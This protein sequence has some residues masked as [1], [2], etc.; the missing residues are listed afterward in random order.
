MKESVKIG[1]VVQ[2]LNGRDGGRC[3]LVIDVKDKFVYLID[4][5]K[6]KIDS[7]KK[8]NI[9][10]VKK[11]SSGQKDLAEKILKGDT[12]GNSRIYRAI[13]V[14]KQKIQED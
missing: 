3:F 10:H 14:E 2:V 7:A 12:V 6:R 5:K 13:S 11:V 4:G 8:K 9:K 1:D